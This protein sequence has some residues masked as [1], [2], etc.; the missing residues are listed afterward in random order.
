MP[1]KVAMTFLYMSFFPTSFYVKYLLS[2]DELNETPPM[3]QDSLIF[4]QF[5]SLN[6]AS[7]SLNIIEHPKNFRFDGYWV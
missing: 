2:Y 4:Y 7:D 3:H 5:N 1:Y 6:Q